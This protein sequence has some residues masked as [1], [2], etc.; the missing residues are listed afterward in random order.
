MGVDTSPSKLHF[1]KVMV[2]MNELHSIR[3]FKCTFWLGIVWEDYNGEYNNYNTQA[4]RIIYGDCFITE[5]GHAS[6]HT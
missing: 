6:L 1:S 2:N 3:V 5:S 4:Y